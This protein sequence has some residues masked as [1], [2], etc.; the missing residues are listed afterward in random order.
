MPSA[1]LSSSDLWSE[2]CRLVPRFPFIYAAFL[3]LR[4]AGWMCRPGLQ[5]G[6]DFVLYRRHPEYVHSDYAA[7]VLPPGAHEVPFLEMQAIGRMCEQ[8]NKGVVYVRIDVTEGFG[9]GCSVEGGLEGLTGPEIAQAL[10]AAHGRACVDHMT[11]ELCEISRFLQEKGRNQSGP[12]RCEYKADLDVAAMRAGGVELPEEGLREL[13]PAELWQEADG[14]KAGDKASI[15]EKGS[16]EREGADD[17]PQEQKKR[18]G[19]GEK[20]GKNNKRRKR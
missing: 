7:L 6:A 15:G 1:P 20:K 2:F 11:L 14:E 17:A 10:A 18:G 5:F 13:L 4:A 16:G 19:R 12:V 8:V 9:Q 3:H